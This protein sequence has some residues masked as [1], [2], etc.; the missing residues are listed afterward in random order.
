M[1]FFS[2]RELEDRL[3]NLPPNQAHPIRHVCPACQ[4]E[5]EREQ[6][7]E[8]EQEP[9]REIRRAEER[10][11]E[12]KQRQEQRREQRR[13]Q[14][15][16][17]LVGVLRQDQEPVPHWLQRSSVQFDRS[18]F[19]GSRTVYYPGSGDDGHPVRLCA[20]AH[21]A[22]A[23]VYVDYGVSQETLQE[24]LRCRVHGFL[25]YDVEHQEEVTEATLR[26]GG[27]T[28][29]IGR[30]DLP[31]QPYGFVSVTPFSLF[32]VLRRRETLDDT[33]GPARLAMLFVG[34]DGYATFDAL[35]CQNDGTPAPFLVLIQDHG[36]G[37]DFDRFDKG[38]LLARIAQRCSVLPKWLLV[39]E[40]S[41]AWSG[42]RD[43]CTTSPGGMHNTPRQL[44]ERV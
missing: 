40:P 2:A 43:T 17:S 29:H 27:W 37:G 10:A 26:P 25:G 19:F 23:F 11:E 4:R 33:H 34:G 32:V 14:E 36:F 38:G 22:H 20:R 28:P 5:Q 7:R 3:K 39:G 21:A 18:D 35:Y 31:G 6:E 42:F 24:T 15:P 30:A 41:A 9:W 44:F 16:C 12:R 1:F 8:R 13:E